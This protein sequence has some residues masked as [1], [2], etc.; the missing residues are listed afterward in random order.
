MGLSILDLLLDVD[1]LIVVDAVKD[2]GQPAGTVVV[3]TPDDIA[4]N[5][6]L[7]SLHDMRLVDVLQNA[8]LLGRSP[9]AV[10][11]GMQIERIE[12]FVLEL[13]PSVEKAL[14]VAVAATLDQL[15]ELGI[16]PKP[17]QGS[18]VHALIIEAMRTYEAMPES[19]LAPEPE[20][21]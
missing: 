14:P 8:A 15:A 9:Q 16:E 11:V 2:T 21:P 6:V 3:M 10:V 12:E 20:A 5:Q 18:N 13:S 19:A 7:H 4:E 17:V 1:R